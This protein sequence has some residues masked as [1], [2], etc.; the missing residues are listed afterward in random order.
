MLNHFALTPDEERELAATARQALV[1]AF[2][3]CI[4]SARDRRKLD[5]EN[6]KPD[7]GR[8]TFTQVFN[9]LAARWSPRHREVRDMSGARGIRNSPEDSTPLVG[10][11]SRYD[12]QADHFTNLRGTWRSG[13]TEET[14]SR[15]RR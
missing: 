1:V 6:R 13:S 8:I 14:F 12:E 4:A 9:A 10:W 2:D 7:V 5:E 3:R 15:W 11:L